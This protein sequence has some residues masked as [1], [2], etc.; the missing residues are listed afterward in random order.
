MS[1]SLRTLLSGA[2]DYAGL[3]PP[4]QLPLDQ[5]IRNYARYRREADAWMLGRFVISATRLA[6]LAPYQDE[7]FRDGLPFAF[8]VLGR[9]G[10]TVV[11]FL[12]GLKADLDAIAKFRQGHGDHVAVEALEAKLP[13]ELVRAQSAGEAAAR[14]AAAAALVEAR[15]GAVLTPFYEATL[16]PEWRASVAAVVAGIARDRQSSD[17]AGRSF[18]LPA[19]FKLRCGG[20]TLSAFPSAEQVAYTIRACVNAEVPL[21][22]TGGLHHPLPRPDSA[23]PARMHGFVNVFVAGVLAQARRLGEEELRALLED[24][25]PGHFHFNDDGLRW[26]H[27][28][29]SIA[30]IH[31]ARQEVVL[32]FGSCSFDKPRDDLRALGWLGGAP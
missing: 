22:F 12:D 28:H 32:S 15:K 19:G 25:V 4:A 3:F 13:E 9:G 2:V 31:A 30:E 8:S 23:T 7:L 1:S 16:G 5:A 18:C 20:Q 10:P 26:K 6:E 27:H 29:A 24:D 21:K 17:A 11:H 14:V